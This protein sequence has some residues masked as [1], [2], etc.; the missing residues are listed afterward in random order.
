MP[1]L[2]LQIDGMSCGHCVAAVKSALAKMD[3]VAVEQVDIG[4]ARVT[5]DPA[6]VTPEQIVDAVNDEGYVA[7]R[8]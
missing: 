1:H 2:T 4:S 6:R 8:E 7:S 3:G 5:Y